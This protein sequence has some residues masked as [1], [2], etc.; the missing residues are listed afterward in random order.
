MSEVD[1][2]LSKDSAKANIY[3]ILVTLLVSKLDK[4]LLKD[5]APWNI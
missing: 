4:L 5:K 1:T 2:S 3:L